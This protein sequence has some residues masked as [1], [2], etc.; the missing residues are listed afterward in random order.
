MATAYKVL[1]QV[2]PSTTTDTT[3]YTAPSATSAVIS[4]VVVCNR[5]DSTAFFRIAVRP[6]G[7][8]LANKHYIAYDSAVGPNNSIFITIGITI[9]ETDVVSVY[10]SNSN[11][12]FSMYGSEIS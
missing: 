9:D 4:S 5:S 6:N 12:S 1:G 3:L 2:S 7:E 10:S 11:L 8:S